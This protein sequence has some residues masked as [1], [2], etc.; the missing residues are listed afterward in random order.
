[1]ILGGFGAG[2][3]G[4][5]GLAAGRPAHRRSL[6]IVPMAVVGLGIGVCMPTCW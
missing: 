6:V 4:F 1:M 5:A 2:S 3:V